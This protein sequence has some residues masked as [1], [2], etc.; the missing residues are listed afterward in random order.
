MKVVRSKRRSLL[1]IVE[2]SKTGEELAKNL[3]KEGF[4]SLAFDKKTK[5]LVVKRRK[6][7]ERLK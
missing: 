4:V 3:A 1:G 7:L 2:Q 6:L 5:K